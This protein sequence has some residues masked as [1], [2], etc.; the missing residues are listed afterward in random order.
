MPRWAS[1]VTLEI[2]GV[3][4]ERVQDI[5]EE[6]A[7][8]EGVEQEFRTVAMHPSGCKDYHIPLSYRGGFA[9]KW[10]EISAKRGY[11]WEMNP[12]VWVIE[13]KRAVS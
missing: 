6:D 11:S 1:R 13:F 4:V 5:S 8:A 3:R 9:N 2:T 12:F 7:Q 10:S